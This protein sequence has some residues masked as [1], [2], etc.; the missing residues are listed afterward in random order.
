M[1]I[2]PFALLLTI[3]RRIGHSRKKIKDF[4]D[5]AFKGFEYIVFSYDSDVVLKLEI[6]IRD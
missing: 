5:I 4:A 3:N 1:K 2:R 6:K